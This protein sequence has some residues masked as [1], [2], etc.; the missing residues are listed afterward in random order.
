M[1]SKNNEKQVKAKAVYMIREGSN[2]DSFWIKLGV[3]F[4]N[5]DDSLNV[6]LDALPLNFDGKLHIRD[7]KERQAE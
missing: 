1:A 6:V 2:G 3:A 5:K 7:F 4:V